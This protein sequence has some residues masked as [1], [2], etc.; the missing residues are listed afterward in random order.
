MLAPDAPESS[1]QQ[2]GRNAAVTPLLR[3][4]AGQSAD[5]RQN[6]FSRQPAELLTPTM[7]ASYNTSF[8]IISPYLSR[9]LPI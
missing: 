8:I 3:G 2:H 4:A 9:F 6:E 5:R 1:P 7:P